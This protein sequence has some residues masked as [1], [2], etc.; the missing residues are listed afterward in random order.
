MVQWIRV[1]F[2]AAAAL[3]LAAWLSQWMGKRKAAAGA[4]TD[5]RRSVGDCF[6][7]A[8]AAA[9]LL[10]FVLRALRLGRLPI[11]GGAD[12][13][14][15]FSLLMSAA[16]PFLSRMTGGGLSALVSLLCLAFFLIVGFFMPQQLTD[17]APLP[18]SLVSPLLS[19]HV[20]TAAF[21]YACF[22][23]AAGLA[24]L[25]LLRE[26]R[27]DRTEGKDKS[28]KLRK[29][30]NRAVDFGFFFLSLTIVLGAVW[31]NAA[32][33]AYWSWDPKETWA[34]IT[35]IIYAIYLHR[36]SRIGKRQAE[37]LLILGFALVIFTF[38]GTNYLMKG[39]HSY[40]G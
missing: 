14:L 35:W 6:L 23:L 22:A 20:F 7:L 31:A 15:L 40:A 24:A 27:P 4:G 2:W 10:L 39:L 26:R 38:F 5:D 36:R 29:A 30:Q 9:G 8:A 33:G 21:S 18:P 28:E 37:L 3:Y 34:L 13:L 11:S 1:L 25:D 32:W 16:A 17:T 19:V 12:F